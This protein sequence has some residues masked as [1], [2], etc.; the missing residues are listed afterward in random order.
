MELSV[1]K[2][3]IKRDLMKWYEKN[4]GSP[5]LID[6]VCGLRDSLSTLIYCSNSGI[7]IFS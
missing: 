3:E 4:E 5:R 6:D 7:F 1:H 2:S